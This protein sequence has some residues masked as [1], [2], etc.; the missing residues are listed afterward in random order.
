[1]RQSTGSGRTVCRGKTCNFLLSSLLC[2]SVLTA[3][4]DDN[5]RQKDPIDPLV[6]EYYLGDGL[7]SNCLLKLASNGSIVFSWTPDAGDPVFFKGNFKMID[8]KLTFT[9]IIKNIRERSSPSTFKLDLRYHPIRWEH[10]LYLIPDV[11]I[12]DFCNAVNLGLEPRST[13]NGEFYLRVPAWDKEVQGLPVVPETARA[14]LLKQPVEGVITSRIDDAA[15][16]NL[17]SRQGI[18]EG[19]KLSMDDPDGQ[20]IV[21]VRAVG[22][23]RSVIYEQKRSSSHKKPIPG[24]KVSSRIFRRGKD[25]KG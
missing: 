14:R 6:G 9:D 1:M 19:M 12:V 10:R 21:T 11:E 15:E 2:S 16:I 7:G 25:D 8:N 18:W 22:A 3:C 5:R 17:G 24:S 13:P 23:D 4:T 20:R